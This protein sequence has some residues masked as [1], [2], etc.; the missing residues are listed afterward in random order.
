MSELRS[1]WDERAKRY[2]AEKSDI[3]AQIAAPRE[4]TDQTSRPAAEGF[5]ARLKSQASR[6]V[7]AI[8]ARKRVW[9]LERQLS[10]TRGEVSAEAVRI[11]DQLFDIALASDVKAGAKAELD[12]MPKS[13]KAFEELR[14]TVAKVA[15]ELE[16]AVKAQ[17]YAFNVQHASARLQ[18]H[19]AAARAGLSL[20]QLAVQLLQ[21]PP[22]LPG[23]VW[24]HPDLH[25]FTSLDLNTFAAN[26]AGEQ[27]WMYTE[28]SKSI[29]RQLEKLKKL[30]QSIG[31]ALQS[32]E[33]RRTALRGEV[34][35]AGCLADADFGSL[36]KAIEA[37]L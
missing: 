24:D 30:D 33:D 7:E 37:W 22:G 16:T 25:A 29:R 6:G 3:D 32:I 17:D 9:D 36:H 35:A 8:K 15:Q 26:R 11:R 14:R 2:D 19:E 28:M 4:S 5:M 31:A 34:I 20:N 21:P 10:A 12:R 18:A 1:R 27:R 13:S 23:S